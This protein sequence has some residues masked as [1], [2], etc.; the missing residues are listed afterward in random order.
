M[1]YW[2]FTSSSGWI[3]TKFP[4]NWSEYDDGDEGTYAFFNTTE[5]SGN[6]RITPY[7]W[8]EEGEDKGLQYVQD[9]LKENEN[10]VLIHLGDWEAAFYSGKASEDSIIYYWVIGFKNT[11]L[12]CSFTADKDLVGSE[13]HNKELMIV[14]EVLSGIKIS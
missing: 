14:E 3:S 8:E 1:N 10:A 11:L 4:E 5:W 9:E 2:E 7:R 13:K 6:L 12:L